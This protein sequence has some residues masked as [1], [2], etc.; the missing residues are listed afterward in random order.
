M[1]NKYNIKHVLVMMLLA[2]SGQSFAESDAPD[3]SEPITAI[4][5]QQRVTFHYRSNQI[6]YSCDGLKH[7]IASILKAVGARGEVD[8]ELRCRPGSVTNS[9]ATLIT[10]RSPIEATPENVATATTYSPETQLVARLKNVQLPTAN[11]LE[12]FNAQWSTVML[13]RA[14]G[15]SIDAGDCEL[16]H[17]LAKQVFPQM[18]VRIVRQGLAC[19]QGVSSRVRPTLHVAALVP[20]PVVP[21]AFAPENP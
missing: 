3:S 8:V 13:N 16:L 1:N 19:A 20:I 5:K 12:R 2:V 10:L 9:A 15:L 7:K 11:D 4:W 6:F 18:A 21:L 14:R 17:G